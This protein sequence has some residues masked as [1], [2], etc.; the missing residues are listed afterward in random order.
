M[1][2]AIYQDYSTLSYEAIA[3]SYDALFQ[4]TFWT[5]S[6]IK[7]FAQLEDRPIRFVYCH[8][9][10]SDKGY[11][12]PKILTGITKQD[13]ALVYGQHMINLLEKQGHLKDIPPY[14]VTGNYRASFYKKYHPLYEEKVKS[15]VLSKLP[16]RKYTL[17]YAPT[18]NDRESLTS[19][20]EKIQGLIACLPDNYNLIIKPHP[21]LKV[22]DPA[23]FFA[24]MPDPLPKGTVSI[25]D[26]PCIYPLLDAVDG[27]IGDFS[28]IGY[29]MLFFEKPMFF[30]DKK[31]SASTK[32]LHA[33][34]IVLP[35][36]QEDIYPTI[37]QHIASWSK[38]KKQA[39]NDLYHLAFGKDLPLE[40]IKKAVFSILA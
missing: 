13:R 23:L 8:H 21:L 33:F 37:D 14:A 19:F 1:V 24:S 18:W 11:E 25:E 16:K 3:R 29:D 31:K 32:N 4:C 15:E 30:F 9:G 28:S 39:Q 20:F 38:E 6:I 35:E 22:K 5:A 36:N 27:Y 12:N 17:L 10:N 26:F 40:E 34:G 7:Y 2:Q